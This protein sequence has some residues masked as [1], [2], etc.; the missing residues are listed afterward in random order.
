[1]KLLLLLLSTL[2]AVHAGRVDPALQARFDR[3]E[4]VDVMIDLPSLD[5]IFD[6]PALTSLKTKAE[7]RTTV[8]QMLKERTA[9]S[10]KPFETILNELGR[11]LTK[12]IWIANR[13]FV[14]NCDAALA[15]VLARVPE[16]FV[17]REEKTV[18]IH[19]SIQTVEVEKE[20][21]Q[22]PPQWGVAMVQAP[23][24]W[25]RYNGSGIVVGIIDTGVHLIHESI[26]M[27]YGGP[28]GWSDPYYNRPEPNDIQSHGTHCIGSVLGS[29][30]GIGVAPGA[31]WTACRGLNDQG[32]GSEA[33]LLAC[34]Q[35]MLNDCVPP[36][37][38]VTN[39]WGGGSDDPWYDSSMRAWIIAG[40]V[41]VFAL[42][43]SGPSCRSHNSPGDSLYCL[44]VGATNAQDNV[45]SFSSR[46]PVGPIQ[47]PE[48]SAPGESV[49]SAGNTGTNTYTSKSGTSM[50]TPHVA[51]AVA[52]LLEQDPERDFYAIKN[53]LQMTGD[54]PPVSPNDANCIPGQEWPNAAF[55]HGRINCLKAID[56]V[57]NYFK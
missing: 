49:I 24:C 53:I 50:A 57:P 10:R 6:S 52:L 48:I 28:G 17:I 7:R 23:A 46:G 47:K 14:E 38:V 11:S 25:P 34:A 1:M 42:G 19:P 37:D 45:A 27:Q 31:R 9:A 2:V 4:V 21:L 33:N 56:Y 5:D 29:V 13:V 43:N 8:V 51:G 41:P 3:G 39:S 36:P 22:D 32:S 18:S 30:N 20:T 35:F 15:D 16:E 55:G 26:N 44:G 12:E 40:M 54:R